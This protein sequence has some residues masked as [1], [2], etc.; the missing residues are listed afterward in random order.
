M[1]L[2]RSSQTPHSDELRLGSINS[3]RVLCVQCFNARLGLGCIECISLAQFSK[4]L[5]NSWTG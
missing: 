1:L 4:S 5:M 3:N 2:A